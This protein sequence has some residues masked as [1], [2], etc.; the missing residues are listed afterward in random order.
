MTNPDQHHPE[1]GND[2]GSRV[3]STVRN[4][5][6]LPDAARRGSVEDKA[7]QSREAETDPASDDPHR[8]QKPA[9]APRP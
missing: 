8:V 4:G 9:T 7:D 6:R 1:G 3:R 2:G 5:V